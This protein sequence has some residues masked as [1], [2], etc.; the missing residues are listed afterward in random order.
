MNK[1]HA[2]LLGGRGAVLLRLS[3]CDICSYD[4]VT[5]QKGLIIGNAGIL[6]GISAIEIIIVSV[7]LEGQ[8]IGWP[9][10]ASVLLIELMNLLV[11]YKG[12]RHLGVVRLPLLLEDILR[13]R[14]DIHPL[15]DILSMPDIDFNI[16]ECTFQL[17]NRRFN[18]STG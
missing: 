11:G 5:Q 7:T 9:V 8:D 13:Q 4:D 6:V 14:F 12:D 3:A 15:G 16:H 1:K 10:N 17:R 18:D 2:Q